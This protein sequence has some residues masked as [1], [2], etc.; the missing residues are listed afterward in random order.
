MRL[1]QQLG[2]ELPLIQ[3]PM[4]GAQDAALTIAVS[5]AGGLGS[6]PSAMLTPQQLR[7]ELSVIRAATDK[8]FNVNFFA[9]TSHPD[10]A[11]EQHWRQ[12]LR[13]YYQAFDLDPDKISASASRSPFNHAMADVIDEFKPA[14]VSFHFGLPNTEL[15]ARVRRAGCQIFSSATTVA[16]AVWLEAQGVDGIIAQGVEAGGHRGFFLDRDLSTQMNTSA[17]V[18]QTLAATQLPVIAAGG[19]ADHAGIRTALSMG[20]AGVQLGT[21]FMLCDESRISDIHRRALLD[22]HASTALTNIFSGGPARG[23]VNRVMRELGP[24]T[25]KAPA[26]PFAGTAMAPLR[27]AAEKQ[28]LGDFSPLWSGQNRHGCRAVGAARLIEELFASR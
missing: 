8:P 5:Q 22:V 15:L 3:A 27:Q 25:D 18:T 17:L 9:H 2:I 11:R 26:F 28:G 10:Q 24:M 13:P 23:I 1:E 16:E 21:V 19:I 12:V 7:A 14:V 4:A 6:L 20:A